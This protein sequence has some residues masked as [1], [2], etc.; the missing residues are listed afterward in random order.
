MYACLHSE[1]E[2]GEAAM[3]CESYSGNFYSWEKDADDLR[4][5]PFVLCACV[6]VC[7]LDSD[8]SGSEPFHINICTYVYYRNVGM[9]GAISLTSV[10][11]SL[12]HIMNFIL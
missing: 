2:N 9:N 8:L 10:L 7:K 5:L 11:A 6:A 4:L 12:M 3:R 1:R